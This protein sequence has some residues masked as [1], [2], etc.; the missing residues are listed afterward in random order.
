[1]NDVKSDLMEQS[2][3]KSRVSIISPQKKQ[4]LVD[5]VQDNEWRKK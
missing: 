4:G 2:N 3:S 5:G 1:M